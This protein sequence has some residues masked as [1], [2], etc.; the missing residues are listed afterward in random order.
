VNAASLFNLLIYPNC[1][2]THNKNGEN[3]AGNWYN[4]KDIQD[5]KSELNE[6]VSVGICLN[7]FLRLYRSRQTSQRIFDTQ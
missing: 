3:I 1:A 6:R 5:A 7:F 4:V 2:N